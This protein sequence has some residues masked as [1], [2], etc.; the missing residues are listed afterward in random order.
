MPEPAV[1]PPPSYSGNARPKD[2]CAVPAPTLPWSDVKVDYSKLASAQATRVKEAVRLAAQDVFY[3]MMM[4]EWMV[5]KPA[6]EQE[7]AW[8]E[9][10]YGIGGASLKKFFGAY[11]Q[12]KVE[13]LRARLEAMFDAFTNENSLVV[14]S[15]SSVTYNDGRRRL[16]VDPT[17][18]GPGTMAAAGARRIEEAVA[19]GVGIKM[20]KLY[21][22][23]LRMRMDAA[24]TCLISKAQA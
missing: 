18:Y 3:A 16:T 24:D 20:P 17:L 7:K 19:L 6:K 9:G 5:T 4:L 1:L 8:S 13:P 23:F 2:Q 14:S 11:D 15:S 12:E 22:A 10:P 21:A